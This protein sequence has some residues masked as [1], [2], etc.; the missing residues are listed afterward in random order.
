M[1]RHPLLSYVRTM[2][3]V[4]GGAT[5]SNRS[6]GTRSTDLPTQLMEGT[7]PN[8]KIPV[9]DIEID[10][11]DCYTGL[12]WSSPEWIPAP[13]CVCSISPFVCAVE[14]VPSQTPAKAI[15]RVWRK[16][17][18]GYSINGWIN[19]KKLPLIDGCITRASARTPSGEENVEVF[20]ASIRRL[21]EG[22]E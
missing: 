12:L 17:P 3:T 4:T 9:R 20:I 10:S 5:S 18:R 8:T 7:S 6:Q 16:F 1:S 13:N 15:M 2:D 21:S 11:V 22:F 19:I 14:L